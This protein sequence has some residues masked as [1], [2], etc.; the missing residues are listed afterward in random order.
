[1]LDEWTLG[2]LTMRQRLVFKRF[3]LIFCSNVCELSTKN[4]RC[5]GKNKYISKTI[6]RKS[7][8][9]NQKIIQCY[10]KA[11]ELIIWNSFRNQRIVLIC[12]IVSKETSFTR[13]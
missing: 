2:L 8:V 7:N 10:T 3:V 1:M 4:Q 12:L 11:Y 6:F 9:L 5:T 13:L